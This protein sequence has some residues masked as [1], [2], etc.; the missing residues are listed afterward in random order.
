MY[1]F[2]NLFIIGASKCGTTSLW[3][4]LNLH[5]DVFMSNPKEL[6]FFSFSD[7][8]NRLDWYMSN[9]EK[10]TNEKIIG[11]A[12]PIYSETTLIPE[13]PQRIYYFN[14]DSKIIYIIR[15]PIDRLKSVWRQTLSSG[16]W[17]E[18]VYEK[19]CDVNVPIMPKN[20]NKAIYEYPSYLEACKYWTHLNNYQ[21]YFNEK[22]IL[23]L[24]FE[25][26]KEN[27]KNTYDKIC[28]FLNI[29]NI[30][31]DG[32][33]IKKNMGNDKAMEYEWVLKIKKNK[34]IS[35][36]YR[37]LLGKTDLN[38]LLPQKRIPYEVKLTQ[39]EIS[40][41]RSCLKD[42]VKSILKYA[43]KPINYWY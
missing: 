28:S 21:R 30:Y 34:I 41:I 12:S 25:E 38:K 6:W 35:N 4:M 20:F 27:P 1:R 18:K 43:N 7:Y 16:H 31:N 11:E 23:L 40:K 5:P 39:Y 24:F 15:E 8:K 36:I 10:V 33:F 3:H 32:M 42:E 17:N 29:E 19:H 2:P 9:F 22:N 37:R 26:F 13:L 14:P